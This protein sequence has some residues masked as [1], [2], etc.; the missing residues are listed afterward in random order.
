MAGYPHMFET[1]WGAG[2]GYSLYDVGDAGYAG[3][4]GSDEGPTHTAFIVWLAIFALAG[5]AVLGGLRFA[6]FHFVVRT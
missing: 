1:M 4:P 2:P 5:V 6:G 3:G